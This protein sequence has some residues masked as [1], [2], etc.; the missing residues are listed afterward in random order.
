[1]SGGREI[2]NI[3][4]FLRGNLEE[5]RLFPHCLSLLP[6]SRWVL[7]E[8]WLSVGDQCPVTEEPSGGLLGGAQ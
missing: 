2:M 7:G 8:G 3:T 4:H 1:M 6:P 5:L